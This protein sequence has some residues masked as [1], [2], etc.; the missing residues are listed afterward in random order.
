MTKGGPRG[1]GALNVSNG[2]T[3]SVGEA[4]ELRIWD[5]GSLFGNGGTIIGDV[6]NAGLIAPG[7][8]FGTLTIDGNLT[9]QS[10][11]SLFF[12]LGGLTQGTEY[13]FL[14]VT[15]LISL[16][17]SL[18]FFILDGFES[19]ISPTD[20]FVIISGLSV[21]GEFFGLS[22]GQQFLTADSKGFF[23]V[24]YGADSVFLNGFVIPEHGTYGLLMG[25]GMLAI[26]M[27]RR[28]LAPSS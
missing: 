12:E 4:S 16:D 21:T 8:S 7:N 26:V 25:L 28:R 18:D 9:L 24:Q 5:T 20:T 14:N 11:S 10:T 6:F 3:V 23:N 27:M 15:G 19:V 22:N 2:G 1:I 17:G 13:D